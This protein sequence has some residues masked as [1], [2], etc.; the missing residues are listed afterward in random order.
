MLGEE[1]LRLR[2]VDRGGLGEASKRRLDMT[3]LERRD[4]PI[5]GQDRPGTVKE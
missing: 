3:F 5:F 4:L 1:D 2:E